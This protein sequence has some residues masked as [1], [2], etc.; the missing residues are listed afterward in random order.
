MPLLPFQQT[1]QNPSA[2]DKPERMRNDVPL[3]IKTLQTSAPVPNFH[4][5]SL[6]PYRKDIQNTQSSKQE[7]TQNPALATTR[8][9]NHRNTKLYSLDLEL[10]INCKSQH[11]PLPPHLLYAFTTISNPPTISQAQH[12]RNIKKHSFDVELN[13]VLARP[14]WLSPY[15][16]H[17]FLS[18][19]SFPSSPP[20]H[21]P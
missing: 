11:H 1:V 14:I 2:A 4:L 6:S 8:T 3:L 15:Q 9:Q 10:N 16:K 12:H 18:F 7:Q 19:P 20:S 17:N 5:N 13:P 21:T